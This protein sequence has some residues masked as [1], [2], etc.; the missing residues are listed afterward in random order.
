[1]IFLIS[2]FIAKKNPP[3]HTPAMSTIQHDCA[4]AR[5]YV[6]NRASTDAAKMAKCAFCLASPSAAA[7]HPSVVGVFVEYGSWNADLAA[8]DAVPKWSEVL[9]QLRALKR[10]G[11]NE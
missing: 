2:L 6:R 4:E 9:R 3:I 5:A 1:L 11:L 8:F 10:G 7:W